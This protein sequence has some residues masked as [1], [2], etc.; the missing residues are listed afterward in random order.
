MMI[1]SFGCEKEGLLKTFLKSSLIG[2]REDERGKKT[3]CS[4][5]VCHWGRKG[6]ES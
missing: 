5:E 3:E 6:D 1:D 4:V 2:K